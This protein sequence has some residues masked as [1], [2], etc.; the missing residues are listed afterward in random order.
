MTQID[1]A[2]GLGQVTGVAIAG[3]RRRSAAPQFFSSLA[4]RVLE[5]ARIWLTELDR[6]LAAADRYE[7]LRTGRATDM[8]LPDRGSKARRIFAEI[9][10]DEPQSWPLRRRNGFA[11]TRA[12]AAGINVR[13]SDAS[14]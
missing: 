1:G 8:P 7:Q 9:Y 6:G 14:P 11:F 4:S 12:A 3:R 10:A 13:P 2:P 5:L